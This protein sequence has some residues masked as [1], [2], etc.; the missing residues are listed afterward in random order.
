M[1]KTNDELTEELLNEAYERG[2]DSLP[3][4]PYSANPYP[5]GTKQHELWR[6]GKQDAAMSDRANWAENDE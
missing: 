3:S 1:P 5:K 4:V 6:R 2:G